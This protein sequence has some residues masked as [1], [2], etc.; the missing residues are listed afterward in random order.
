MVGKLGGC[1]R[2]GQR[3]VGNE[4]GWF[5]QRFVQY[6]VGPGK[7]THGYGQIGERRLDLPSVPSCFS[8]PRTRPLRANISLPA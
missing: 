4:L 1:S 7:R 6:V 5:V 8:M 2:R 3:N